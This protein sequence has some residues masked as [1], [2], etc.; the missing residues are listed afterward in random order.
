MSA[1]G[2]CI[3]PPKDEVR[4]S[5]C[6]AGDVLLLIIYLLFTLCLA[7]HSV[8]GERWLGTRI[9]GGAV[10]VP[11]CMCLWGEEAERTGN[12]Y[13]RP[14]C[15]CVMNLLQASVREVRMVLNPFLGDT[16]YV[17]DS[18]DETTGSVRH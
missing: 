2:S 8:L 7:K 13:Q 16:I 14:E 1:S 10:L 12:E 3:A 15:R 18:I 6:G 9:R 17:Y 11:E 5:A 4:L